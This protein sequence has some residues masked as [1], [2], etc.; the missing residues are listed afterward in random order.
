MP[1]ERRRI[2]YSGRVQGVG[3]RATCRWLAGGFEL[4]GYV[5][6]LPD[7]CVEVVAEGEPAELDRFQAAV[8]D[9]MSGFIRNIDEDSEPPG[10]PPLQGFS[11]RF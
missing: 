1:L 4:A 6:N 2:R 9:Q 11:V 10:S 7:G 3:F 5:R 8:Q